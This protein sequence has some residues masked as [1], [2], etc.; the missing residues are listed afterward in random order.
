MTARRRY[1]PEERAAAAARMRLH[2]MRKRLGVRRFTIE[3]AGDQIVG[4]MMRGF[5]DEN[6]IADDDAVRAALQRMIDDCDEHG[7]PLRLQRNSAPEALD[8]NGHDRPVSVI[9]KD[10]HGTGGSGAQPAFAGHSA[11]RREEDKS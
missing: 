11:G 2:R 7:H 6:T 10:E 4:L 8:D 5:L 9:V 3:L 1:G